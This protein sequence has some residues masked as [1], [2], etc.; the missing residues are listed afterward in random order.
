[1]SLNI[2]SQP[3]QSNN[4]SESSP[5]AFSPRSSDSP[6][7]ARSARSVRSPTRF[8]ISIEM[9]NPRTIL[10]S[11]LVFLAMTLLGLRRLFQPAS[12]LLMLCL[13]AM[14]ATT[15]EWN[16]L[17]SSRLN[18]WLSRSSEAMLKEVEYATAQGDLTTAR[19]VLASH[20]LTSPLAKQDDFVSA[21]SL[22]LKREYVKQNL[23][24]VEALLLEHP[25]AIELL[26]RRAKLTYA[27]GDSTI[28]DDT[29]NE[30]AL[31]MPNDERLR[32]FQQR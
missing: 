29:L 31:I 5:S 4:K 25:Y 9:F 24:E 18:Y 17:S 14:I 15:A 22:I 1:M 26:A 20:L 13:V 12:I 19:G 30:W 8:S 3:R 32:I 11:G 21:T 6:R 10:S 27:L 23:Q 28:L 2:H 7:S 16:A